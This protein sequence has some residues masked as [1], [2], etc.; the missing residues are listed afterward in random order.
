MDVVRTGLLPSLAHLA[1]TIAARRLDGVTAKDWQRESLPRW[2]AIRHAL[3][4]CFAGYHGLRRA[5]ENLDKNFAALQTGAIKEPALAELRPYTL[6][7]QYHESPDKLVSAFE[8][9]LH[10][11][12]VKG[13]R[14][15]KGEW[16]G[17]VPEA[18][19][20]YEAVSG[21]MAAVVD[22][23]KESASS[24]AGY[25][26]KPTN[27]AQSMS[28]LAKA[29]QASAS[30]L[31]A[32]A[33]NALPTIEARHEYLQAV[34]SAYGDASQ[35]VL[36]AAGV[37]P[38]PTDLRQSASSLAHAASKSAATAYAEASQSA[39]RALGKEPSPTDL[40]QSMTSIANVASASAASAYSQVVSDYPASI[41]SALAAATEAVDRAADDALSGASSLAASA[42]SVVSSLAAP[43]AT[44]LNPAPVADAIE[45]AKERANEFFGDVS[46]DALRAVGQEPSPTNLAQ[47]ATSLGNAVSSS[48]S[49]A[50]KAAA[51]N[52]SARRS[53]ASASALASVSARARAA[54]RAAAAS[55]SGVSASA[56]S[57]ASSVSSRAT[58][59]ASSASSVAQSLNQPHPSYKKS[60]A[61]ASVASG[62]D[63][64]KRSASSIASAASRKVGGAAAA[65]ASATKRPPAVV[66]SA[67]N[68]ASAV[69]SKAD[70][71]ASPHPSYA[72]SQR[73]E[74]VAQATDK[75][76]KVVAHGEL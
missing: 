46:Q 33:V 5:E 65:A 43:A 57:L 42:A 53:S 68:V 29:A 19:A 12:K 75:V 64:V 31:A 7:D 38:A 63:A 60:Q 10:K 56:S 74:K 25:E 3:T 35:Q 9:I 4:A 11:I 73:Q 58:K 66:K 39:L 67:S 1:L 47:S 30:S 45:G 69:K 49:S 13:Q 41:S 51:S 6:L 37:E 76:K 34:K 55:A 59:A 2:T 16:Q 27:V 20:A 48:L 72:K 14:E 23:L 24:V 15:L 26:R 18:H 36:R 32:E 17:I 50:G 52:A 44:M 70:D 54:T 21:K 71:L 8:K 22:D 62:T 28:S 61:G 40:A